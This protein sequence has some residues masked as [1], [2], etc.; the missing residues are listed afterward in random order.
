MKQKRYQVRI[1]GNTNLL[2]PGQITYH[3]LQPNR[4][5]DVANRTGS[6]KVIHNLDTYVKY[7]LYCYSQDN[8][9]PNLKGQ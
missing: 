2:L 8:G 7:I 4:Y 5:F 6:I 3:L 1:V 9:D